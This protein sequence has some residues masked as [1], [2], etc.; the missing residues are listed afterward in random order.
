VRSGD[1]SDAQGKSA[2]LRDEGAHR[3]GFEREDRAF[4]LLDCVFG[5]VKVRYRG[6][7]KNHVWLC[8][9]FAAIDVNQHR[10]RPARINQRLAPQGA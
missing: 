7:E 3:R 10:K 4:G 6:L 9:A 8:V 1:A 5:F 2:V